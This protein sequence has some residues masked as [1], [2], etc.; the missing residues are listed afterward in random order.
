MKC[1][2]DLA[3][4]DE[5]GAFFG[6]SCSW[7]GSEAPSSLDCATCF[8][9]KVVVVEPGMCRVRDSGEKVMKGVFLR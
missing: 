1:V 7:I 3:K 8:S 4:G 2:H 9:D 6:P 5:A